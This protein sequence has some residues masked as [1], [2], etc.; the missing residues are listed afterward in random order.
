[1]HIST[2]QLP[3][4][5]DRVC[6]EQ[7]DFPKLNSIYISLKK[8]TFHIQIFLKR[9]HQNSVKVFLHL[10]FPHI[11]KKRLFSFAPAKYE[12]CLLEYVM[13]VPE[14]LSSN[15]LSVSFPW[16]TCA[17]RVSAKERWRY[18]E[19]SVL[20]M[21]LG[22]RCRSVTKSPCYPSRKMWENSSEMC[23]RQLLKGRHCPVQ[24]GATRHAGH[25]ID[26]NQNN[27]TNKQKP[28]KQKT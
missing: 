5:R 4:H 28:N 16:E 25:S 24:G 11:G 27:T 1:M 2:T 17:V 22:Q 19:L 6:E 15:M 26:L 7:R 14:S 21:C 12:S 10:F 20:C 3:T 23:S 18:W 9:K 8:L 13:H